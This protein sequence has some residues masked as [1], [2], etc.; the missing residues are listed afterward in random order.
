[1]EFLMVVLKFLQKNIRL[2][3]ENAHLWS[4][5][6]K[7]LESNNK[8]QLAAEK[9]VCFENYRSL[10]NSVSFENWRFFR[11]FRKLKYVPLEH[12]AMRNYSR[13]RNLRLNRATTYL[14]E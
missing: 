7:I 6:L 2:K 8:F 3:G 13:L 5:F 10:K 11:L 12:S 9:R 1:M 14:R 4:F